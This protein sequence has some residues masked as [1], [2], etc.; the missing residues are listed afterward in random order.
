MNT[1]QLAWLAI[2]LVAL[3]MGGC[4]SKSAKPDDAE[5]SAAGSSS[6]SGA[7][8]AAASSGSD[9]SVDPLDDPNSPLAARKVYF[10][11]DRSEI[12]ADSIPVLR[13]HANFLINNNTVGISIQ[14]HCDERGSREYNIGLG[15]R[16]AEAVKRFLEAQGVNPSQILTVSYGEEYPDAEGH[17]ETAWAANRRAV[18]VY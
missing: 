6:S 14:G 18:I 11:F 8:T 3:V 17:N 4:S 10:D 15:E 5:G 13:V 7:S 9:G 12:R 16:R 1:N 2:V